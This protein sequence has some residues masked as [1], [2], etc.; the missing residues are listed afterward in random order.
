LLLFHIK[1][2]A[3]LVQRQRTNRGQH[4]DIALQEVQVAAL[5]NQAMNYLISNKI[6]QRLGN[7]ILNL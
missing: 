3:A 2:L 7:V 1:V 4:I 6:P 5:A